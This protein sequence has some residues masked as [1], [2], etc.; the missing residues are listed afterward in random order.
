MEF[1]PRKVNYNLK[2]LAILSLLCPKASWVQLHK[3][4]FVKL[5]PQL[6]DQA[7]QCPLGDVEMGTTNIHL[8][9][10]VLSSDCLE[11]CELVFSVLIHST[12]TKSFTVKGNFPN[13]ISCL[14]KLLVECYNTTDINHLIITNQDRKRKPSQKNCACWLYNSE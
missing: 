4:G 7:S 12:L 2:I 13:C 1:I 6:R 11:S 14:S 5:Y 10:S 8:C 3:D 9:Y